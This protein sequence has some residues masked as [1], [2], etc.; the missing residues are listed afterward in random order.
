M[1]GESENDIAR[2]D[3]RHKALSM[4][5]DDYRRNIDEE[6]KALKSN[7]R[8]VAIS[9]LGAVIGAIARMLFSN[10]GLP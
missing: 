7:Q 3:E 2:L 9:V 6:I 5:L 1:M 8:W 10:G 4:R